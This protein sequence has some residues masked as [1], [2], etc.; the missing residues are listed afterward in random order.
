MDSL[1]LGIILF[2][3]TLF[4]GFVYL[5]LE[6]DLGKVKP[7]FMQTKSTQPYV[8]T[9]YNKKPS[10]KARL[11]VEI[12]GEIFPIKIWQVRKSETDNPIND[13]QYY[14]GNYIEPISFSE[15]EYEYAK[16]TSTKRGKIIRVRVLGEYGITIEK[17]RINHLEEMLDRKADELDTLRN[18]LDEKYESEEIQ[19]QRANQKKSARN[20]SGSMER[21]GRSFKDEED[22][23]DDEK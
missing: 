7:R 17:Q 12:K 8:I 3:G 22:E 15:D 11:E 9:M 16:I 10:S 1:T 20:K 4:I 19:K 13:M 14:A 18:E 21:K 5:W 6:G 2:T 23:E